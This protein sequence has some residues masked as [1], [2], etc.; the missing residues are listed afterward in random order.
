MQHGKERGTALYQWRGGNFDAQLIGLDMLAK[1]YMSSAQ[2]C[3]VKTDLCLLV[4]Q[5]QRRHE[6]AA[7]RG[8]RIAKDITAEWS[9]L[10]TGLLDRIAC[11]DRI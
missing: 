8:T 9:R 4:S 7:P 2:H 11:C 1:V 5:P 6:L 3:T 10:T